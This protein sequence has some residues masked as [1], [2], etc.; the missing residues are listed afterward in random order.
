MDKNYLLANYDNS[1]VEEFKTA[2]YEAVQSIYSA[3]TK[4]NLQQK[5]AVLLA[6]LDKF[7]ATHGNVARILIFDGIYYKDLIIKAR[8]GKNSIA[9]DSLEWRAF[10]TKSHSIQDCLEHYRLY[11]YHNSISREKDTKKQ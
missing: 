9:I 1:A 6:E 10:V 3:A 4:G 2:E 11:L 7:I 8:K 5:K